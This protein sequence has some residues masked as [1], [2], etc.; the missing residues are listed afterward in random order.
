MYKHKSLTWSIVV[1]FS[2]Q[3]SCFCKRHFT[4]RRQVG[5]QK[6]KGTT[7]RIVKEKNMTILVLCEDSNTLGHSWGFKPHHS[8]HRYKTFLQ[9]SRKTNSWLNVCEDSNFTLCNNGIKCSTSW[10][11]NKLWV[12]LFLTNIHIKFVKLWFRVDSYEDS[13]L[14]STDVA[15]RYS[16]CWRFSKSCPKNK[17]GGWTTMRLQTLDL[18]TSPSALPAGQKKKFGMTFVRIQTSL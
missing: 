4:L 16:T 11:E 13:H 1:C 14:R 5:S 15:I 17:K 3:G 18:K 12:V 6:S 8:Q 9:Q 10:A 2:A 7:Y